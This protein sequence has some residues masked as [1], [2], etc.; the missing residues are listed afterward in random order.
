MQG[1]I[2]QESVIPLRFTNRHGLLGSKAAGFHEGVTEDAW[3]S[4]YV[5]IDDLLAS[6][7]LGMQ[8]VLVH[9]LRERT[10]TT[11]YAKRIGSERS[12]ERRVGEESRSRW[13][14]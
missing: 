11:N 4:G 14:P 10:A 2:D 9:F 12:E 6:S 5:D 3:S 7:D 1:F 13:S 8:E